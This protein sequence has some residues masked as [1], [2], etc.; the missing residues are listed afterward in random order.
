MTTTKFALTV[1]TLPLLAYGCACTQ[2]PLLLRPPRGTRKAALCEDLQLRCRDVGADVLEWAVDMMHAGLVHGLTCS[3]C[4]PRNSLWAS[5]CVWPA[6]VHAL[7]HSPQVPSD[8]HDWHVHA[9][10]RVHIRAQHVSGGGYAAGCNSGTSLVALCAS[11]ESLPWGCVKVPNSAC[12]P[13]VA[14]MQTQL[15][16]NSPP[17]RPAGSSTGCTRPGSG[18]CCARTARGARG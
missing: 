1:R 18:P 2:A 5:S 7:R 4:L 17:L 16:P 12:A 9:W 6:S 11:D 3:V 8:A 13:G 14:N 10:R 15:Q